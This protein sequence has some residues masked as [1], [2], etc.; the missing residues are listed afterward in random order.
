[1]GNFPIGIISYKVSMFFLC[2][3]QAIRVCWSKT[4]LNK[5]KYAS[6]LEMDGIV[7]ILVFYLALSAVSSVI[8]YY[9]CILDFIMFSPDQSDNSHFL[10]L[11][12]I[13]LG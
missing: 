11:M 8:L 2:S 1:V 10:M 13:C 9:V 6:L 4:R 12:C 7:S 3:K 5:T